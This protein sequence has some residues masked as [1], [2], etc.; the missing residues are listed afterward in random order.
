M[1]GKLQRTGNITQWGLIE[2]CPK[3][4]GSSGLLVGRTLVS[5]QE[6]VVPVQ[7]INC[8][9]E[10]VTLHSNQ[11]LG[12]CESVHW[13]ES[14]ERNRAST[15]WEINA[16]KKRVVK[17][18]AIEKNTNERQVSVPAHL[19]DLFE[20]STQHLDEKQREQLAG[21][22]HQYGDIFSAFKGDVGRTGLVKHKI[23]T[24]NARPIKQPP[25]RLPFAKR[26]I[27]KAEG[28]ELEESIYRYV[29]HKDQF[30]TLSR[31]PRGFKEA[32]VAIEE[33]LQKH[34]EQ[35]V[36]AP[37]LPTIDDELKQI[38]PISTTP[39]ATKD[40]GRR[41]KGSASGDSTPKSR[42]AS[43]TSTSET[44]IETEVRAKRATVKAATPETNTSL[45]EASEASRSAT[46]T[47]SGTSIDE[48]L[49]A[50]RTTQKQNASPPLITETTA[51]DSSEIITENEN[52]KPKRPKVKAVAQ[53]KKH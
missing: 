28:L 26:E 22:L 42:S 53:K 33:A 1:A 43:G 51:S 45:L 19:T 36:K 21:M 47:T 25:R 10:P 6:D 35:A 29:D 50:K 12:W 8:G 15:Y 40:Y 39:S 24:G 9:N 3:L 2:P 52:A 38:F 34:P 27:E 48:K 16:I 14:S 32:L 4:I 18:D 41:G 23:D 37:E 5:A 20:R 31:V 44:V 11:L 30:E 17:E 13:C 49:T 46:A 7:V